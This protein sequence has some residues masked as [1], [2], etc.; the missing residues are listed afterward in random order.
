MAKE[1]K[2]FL[3]DTRPTK[4]VVV[5]GITRDAT[6]EECVFDL[7]DNSIDA[8]RNVIFHEN[9][10]HRNEIPDDYS[11]YKI[12]LRFSG[13]GFSIEDNC[14]G[15]SIEHLRKEALRFGE[16]GKQIMGIG[17]FGVGL[18]RALFRLGRFSHIVT[19]T[20][21]ERAEINIDKEAYTKQ[22]E[23]NWE[24][25]A[26]RLLS[27]GKPGTL[28]EIN[29]PPTETARSFGN[30][31]WIRALMI[32]ISRRYGRF[33]RKG[34]AI[35]VGHNLLQDGEIKIR[36]DS[37]FESQPKF[38]KTPEGVSIYIEYGQ[39]RLH[40]FPSESGQDDE[41]NRRLTPQYGWTILCNDR[42]IVL[43]DKTTKTG[44]EITKFH[45]DFYGFVGNVNFI[46]SDPKLLPWTT[47]KTDVDLNN[48]AYQ[49]AL[50]DMRIF[51]RLWRSAAARRKKAQEELKPL[52]P[53]K[54]EVESKP[55]K[56]KGPRKAKSKSVKQPRR[57]DHNQYREVLPRD[58]QEMHCFD[59]HLAL[60]NEAKR[61]DMV[62]NPYAGLALTR[63]LFET[64]AVKFLERYGKLDELKQFAIDRRRK[65]GMSVSGDREK[66]AI[67]SMDE[68][69]AYFEEH[70]EIWGTGKQAYVR[71]SVGN[72]GANQKMMNSA[73]HHPFQPI[74]KTK[75]IEIRDEALPL[76]RHLIEK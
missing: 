30:E 52:P 75:A 46:S 72:M 27:T 44:W 62:D 54:P 14:G 17:A 64:S 49:M 65:K 69:L 40:H 2:Q 24:I 16:G 32:Q 9:P 37:S 66:N 4:A 53:K 21:T 1:G 39:H 57:D 74:P 26:T 70:S 41:Q 12:R 34:L 10:Q 31:A 18:N 38:Y 5:D 60:V 55:T 29:N 63:M 73:L 50:K 35:W 23:K 28:V 59:K 61:I 43:S 76:L 68:I 47:T 22:S 15:I 45:S 48:P 56:A 58:I 8:A 11:G 7:I 3:I 19:D 20:G 6:D 42:A 51:T 25:P 67:A 13:G 33:I 36:E 71:H